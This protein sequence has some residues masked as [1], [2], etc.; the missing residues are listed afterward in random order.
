MTWFKDDKMNVER[1]ERLS[2]FQVA[3]QCIVN[4]GVTELVVVMLVITT[5]GW[6]VCRKGAV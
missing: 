6:H 2:D 1:T 5:L 4:T 3:G